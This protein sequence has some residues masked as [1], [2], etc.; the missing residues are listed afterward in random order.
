MSIESF[1]SGQRGRRALK[2]PHVVYAE[3]VV[4]EASIV[5]REGIVPASVGDYVLSD[6]DGNQWPV[7]K[8]H[9]HSSYYIIE[10]ATNGR[11]KLQ[12]RSVA[13]EVMQLTNGI[14]VP[15]RAGGVPLAGNPG[16]WLVRYPSGDLGIVASHLFFSS[17]R[18]LE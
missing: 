18:L 11:L 16:D 14:S 15:I 8:Q 7:S 3:Q 13:V 10:S 1:L 17:Y 5:T 9:F 12:G 4:K 2:L 6:D